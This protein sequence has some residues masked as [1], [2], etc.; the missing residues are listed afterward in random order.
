MAEEKNKLPQGAAF[1]LTVPL[2][3][4]REKTATFHIKE[5]EEEVFMAAK[6]MIDKGKDFDAVRM[7]IKAL[8]V[9]GDD[10][11]LLK[12]NFL[13]CQAASKLIFEFLAPVDG[14]LKK[15]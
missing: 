12:S 7:I 14:E 9:G 6:A 4:N 11:G 13:A 2:D 10:V 1:T 5:M 8:Q 3:R 15:N